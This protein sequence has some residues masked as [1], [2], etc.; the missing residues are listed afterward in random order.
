MHTAPNCPMFQETFPEGITNGAAWYSVTGGMQDWNYVYAGVFEITLELG[1]AKYPLGKELVNFWKDNREALV[2]YIE[3]VHRG[4]YGYVRS[5]IGTA[6]VNA[7]ITIGTSP[8]VVYSGSN[9]EYWRLLLP[10]RYNLTVEADGYEK[11][12]EEI[13][14]D[15]TVQVLRLDFSLMRD[16][17][18]HWSS[19]YDYRILASVI[20]T[21][22]VWDLQFGN[23][24]V[25]TT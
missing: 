7:T 18:Q 8:H 5:S 11:H 10:G 22:L 23:Y 9:G 16:D 1:C 24:L 21:R 20:K 2:T 25:F 13:E 15:G 4:A 6:I 3:Q 14:I 17:P 19:A 12:T